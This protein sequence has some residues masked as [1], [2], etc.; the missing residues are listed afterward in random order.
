MKYIKNYKTL[1]QKVYVSNIHINM[2]ILNYYFMFQAD[3]TKLLCS[4]NI[5]Q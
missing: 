4:R 3:I 5:L 2:N 1:L